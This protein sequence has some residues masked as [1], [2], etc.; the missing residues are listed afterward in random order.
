L[1]G[2]GAFELASVGLAH[3]HNET[4]TEWWRNCFKVIQPRRLGGA[5]DAIPFVPHTV[6][7]QIETAD[8]AGPIDAR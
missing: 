1:D 3:T 4:A 6:K 7:N 2:N 8:L 5:V